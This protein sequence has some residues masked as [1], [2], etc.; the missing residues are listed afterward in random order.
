MRSCPGAGCTN[1]VDERE[2]CPDCLTYFPVILDDVARLW[3]KAHVLLAVVGRPPKEK[4]TGKA[5]TPNSPV[6]LQVLDAIESTYATVTSWASTVVIRE[7]DK[8]FGY[9]TQDERMR[10]SLDYLFTTY[11]SLRGS[12]LLTNC[13][14]AIYVCRRRLNRLAGDDPEVER[15]IYPCPD[16]GR[17]SLLNRRG[18]DHIQCLTCSGAWGQSVFHRLAHERRSERV[19]ASLVN[20]VT[21][22]ESPR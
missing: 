8:A 16:C 4:V 14:N 10:L 5:I 18:G 1:S 2:L 7:G 6:N 20:A 22:K 17:R 9:V 19:K 11:L 21:G 12:P 13:Y 3:V 15:L